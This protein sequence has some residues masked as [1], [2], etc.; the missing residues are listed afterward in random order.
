MDLLTSILLV[1]AGAALMALYVGA[2][3]YRAC[4]KRGMAA[5]ESLGAAV[6]IVI[7]PGGGGGPGPVDP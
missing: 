2:G 3:T 5:G 7:K 4:R 6:R 1:L